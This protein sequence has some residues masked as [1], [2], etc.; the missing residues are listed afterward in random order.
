[1]TH[2]VNESSAMTVRARF[3]NDSGDLVT[4]STARYL[5]RDISNDRLVRDWTSVTPAATIDIAVSATD[6]ELQDSHRRAK[7]FERRVV[8][9]QADQGTPTQRTDEIEYWVR[10]LAGITND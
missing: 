8:T 6:N 2:Y 10:N 3:F 4:P 5:I 9:V 1:M 7:R